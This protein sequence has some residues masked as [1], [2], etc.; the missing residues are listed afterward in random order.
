[1]T[2]FVVFAMLVVTACGASS[3]PSSMTPLQQW[4]AAKPFYIAHRGGDGS[5]PESTAYAYERAAAWNPNL[6]LE[7]PVWRTSDGVWVVSEDGSTGRVFGSDYVIEATRWSTLAALRTR[8]GGHP[9]ARLVENILTPYGRDRILFVDDKADRNVGSLLDLLDSYGGNG[10]CVIKSFWASGQAPAQARARGYLT[11]GYY[12]SK[13]MP[14]FAA[15]QSKF[16]TLGLN[17]DAP[18][19]DFAILS[20]TGK[21]IIAHIIRSAAA[22]ASSLRKGAQGL[23]I[24][25]VEKVVPQSKS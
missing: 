24:S 7:I 18:T 8:R 25:A 12:Y 16:D 6:A 22:A 17:Y 3:T 15:T 13:D 21:P 1:M 4:M 5:W 9:M 23:M 14:H 10:R 20:A 11:W 2:W 19:V